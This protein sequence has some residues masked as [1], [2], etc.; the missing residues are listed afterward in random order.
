[1]H[2]LQHVVDQWWY[3]KIW[4]LWFCFE[5]SYFERDM[6]SAFGKYSDP[7]PLFIFFF[8]LHPYCKMDS[9]KTFLIYL[10]TIP[11]YYKV[12]TVI[13]ISIQTLCYEIR[14]WAQVQTVYIDHPWDVSTTLLQSTCGKFNWLYMI[15]KGTHLSTYGPTVDRACQIINQAMRSKE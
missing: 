11:H 13:Y 1:M 4:Q 8:T 12:K 14:N 9:I 10:H 6:Y 5:I 3:Q 2:K 7:F 15:W